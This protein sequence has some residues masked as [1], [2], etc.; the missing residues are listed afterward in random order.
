[1]LFIAV[2]ELFFVP[3]YADLVAYII[4]TSLRFNTTSTIPINVQ[5]FEIKMVVYGV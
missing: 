5:Q 4:T 2:P 1:M 3:F